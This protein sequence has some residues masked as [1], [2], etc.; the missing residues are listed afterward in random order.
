MFSP[1]KGKMTMD[2]GTL[3][4]KCKDLHEASLLLDSRGMDMWEYSAGRTLPLI[5]AQDLDAAGKVL[6][7]L[8]VD[9]LRGEGTWNNDSAE[10]RFH[11]LV[12]RWD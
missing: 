7:E 2:M 11:E 6:D 9:L 8:I 1:W 10:L 5:A 3:L 12:G 4:D